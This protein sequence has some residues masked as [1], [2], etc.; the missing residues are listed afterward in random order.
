MLS[1]CST[2]DVNTSQSGKKESKTISLDDFTKNLGSS[3]YQ[4]VDTRSDE[5]YN[6]FKTNGIKNGGYLKN[7][8][9]Y[10]TTSIGKFNKD[11]ESKPDS[12]NDYK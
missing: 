3:E 6:G 7:S 9:Q 8:I 10:S 1:G 12:K 2:K 4:F 5:A 11:K